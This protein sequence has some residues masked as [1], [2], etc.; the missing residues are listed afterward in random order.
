[1][2]GWEPKDRMCWARCPQGTR[3]R[4]SPSEV[5][6][7][8]NPLSSSARWLWTPACGT[9][10]PIVLSGVPMSITTLKS[11][12]GKT[13]SCAVMLPSKHRTARGCHITKLI[14]ELHGSSERHRHI[15]PPN[16]AQLSKILYK[17]VKFRKGKK[18]KKK[19]KKV[20]SSPAL[21]CQIWSWVLWTSK[22]AEWPLGSGI[23]R[24]PS[25]KVTP[26][27]LCKIW[28]NNPINTKWS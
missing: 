3:L 2:E 8:T 16:G 7:A 13:T 14:P 5:S 28:C 9:E 4:F 15:N 6:R 11:R 1:M 23:K 18:K 25:N 19:K 12:H 22:P 24:I 27:W 21:L 20:T 10:T 17:G 26:L